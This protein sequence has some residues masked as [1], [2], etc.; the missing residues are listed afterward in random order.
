M[1]NDIAIVID[2]NQTFVLSVFY[3]D[4]LFLLVKTQFVPIRL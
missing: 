4:Y 3:D 1:N 2:F